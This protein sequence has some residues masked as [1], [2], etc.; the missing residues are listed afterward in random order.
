MPTVHQGGLQMAYIDRNIV[1]PIDD[2][3][4]QR[5]ED[6]VTVSP[7]FQVVIPAR[8]RQQ[9][10]LHPGAK[11]QAM[12]YAGQ[13]LFVPVPVLRSLRGALAGIDTAVPRDEP[14][15]V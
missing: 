5:M 4:V 8:L 1:I 7:K 3:C 14:D 15:R 9:L 11:L 2:G 6:V 10:G 13:L 12:V